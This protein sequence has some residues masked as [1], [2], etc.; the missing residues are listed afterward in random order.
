MG[1]PDGARTRAYAHK[2]VC[3]VEAGVVAAS[4]SAVVPRVLAALLLPLVVGAA[5]VRPCMRAHGV[6]M[7]A[8]ARR[9]PSRRL[10]CCCT[11]GQVC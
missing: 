8:R 7:C 6:C 4:V 3:T 10:L 2:C 9:S 1:A 5:G 11:P